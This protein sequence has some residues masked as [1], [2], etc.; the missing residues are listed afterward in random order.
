[1]KVLAY[2]SVIFLVFRAVGSFEAFEEVSWMDKTRDKY[3]EYP[4]IS[5]KFDERPKS[6]SANLVV[7]N[8]IKQFIS[9]PRRH[10]SHQSSSVIDLFFNSVKN[11][12]KPPPPAVIRPENETT[13]GLDIQIEDRNPLLQGVV[14]SSQELQLIYLGTKW[15]GSGDIATSRNDV[16]YFYMTG[17]WLIVVYFSAPQIIICQELNTANL[18]SR[19]LL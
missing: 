5:Y 15:C 6:E 4:E 14:T 11:V 8:K 19:R 18:F 13:K 12:F 9:L 2:F 16:G 3:F 10:I 17:N 1:M 7:P